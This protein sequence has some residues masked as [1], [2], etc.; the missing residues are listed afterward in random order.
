MAQDGSNHDATCI[1]NFAALIAKVITVCK[2][3]YPQCR[4]NPSSSESST[5]SRS[6]TWNEGDGTSI[7]NLETGDM[8]SACASASVSKPGSHWNTPYSSAVSL[9]S[10]VSERRNTVPGRLSLGAYITNHQDEESIKVN[11]FKG[12][13]SKVDKL[14]KAFGRRYTGEYSQTQYEAKVCEDMVCVLEKMLVSS[15][16]LFD[17]EE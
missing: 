8:E 10:M 15:L 2:S 12:E 14:I 17:R 13:V 4:Q 16:G 3:V 9:H 7:F 1:L 6:T 5:R 11:V